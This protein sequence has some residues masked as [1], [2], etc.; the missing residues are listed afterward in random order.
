MD[1]ISLNKFKLQETNFM[2]LL[3]EE[4]ALLFVVTFL[5]T[6]LLIKVAHKVKLVDTPNHRSFHTNVTP[7]GGGLIFSL[8]V[9]IF[10]SLVQ[11]EIVLEHYLIFIAILLVTLIGIV[12]DLFDVSPKLKFLVIFIATLLLYFDQVTINSLGYY[13]GYEVSLHWL[14]VFPFTFF[15]IA[16][17]T[18]ALNLIDGIDGLSTGISIIIL[19][20]FLA[21]GITYQD[22]FLILLSS[23]FITTLLAFL[24][25]NWHPAKIFMGDAGSLTLGF[26][27]AVLAIKSLE[28]INPTAILFI[29]AMPILDTFMVILRRKQRSL[30]I[31]K[32]DKNHL[33]HI[34]YDQKKDVYFTTVMLW[35]LQ[36]VFSIIG[37]RSIGQDDSW[38]IL[39]FLLLFFIFFSLFDPRLRKRKKKYR[40]KSKRHNKE[41]N[42]IN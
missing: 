21:I 22:Q 34:L 26:T 40:K 42:E 32:A 3:L 27:I 6:D 19:S 2:I 23:A 30:S 33:H 5:L 18:N 35:M 37:Y 12:D 25:F 8:A 15:A 1:I 41:N 16:G 14:L 10:I 20:T 29:G 13:F 9:L 4:L 28:Y 17:F 7:K 24:V 31:F 11:F 38:N 39:L 36:L